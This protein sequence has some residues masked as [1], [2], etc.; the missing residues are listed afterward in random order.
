[1][2]ITLFLISFIVAATGPWW[3]LCALLALYI[4]RWQGLE[5]LLLAL[6]ADIFFHQQLE[7]PLYTLLTAAALLFFIILSPYLKVYNDQ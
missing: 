2:R 6:M 3:L 7:I 4:I 1:M 5:V